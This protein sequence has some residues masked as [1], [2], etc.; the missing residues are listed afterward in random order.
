MLPFYLLL[1]PIIFTLYFLP[2]FVAMD[3]CHRDE[4]SIFV[5]NIVGGVTVIGW[6]VAMAWSLTS[7]KNY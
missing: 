3:K 6:L 2:S 5:L 1:I 4:K 7:R